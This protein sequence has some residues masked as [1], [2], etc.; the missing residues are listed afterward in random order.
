MKPICRRSFALLL[1]ISLLC[2]QGIAFAAGKEN[3]ED[4]VF[5][6]DCSG[7][8]KKE[9]A[10]Y[11][12]RELYK[13]YMDGCDRDR[14]HMGIVCFSNYLEYSSDKL[15]SLSTDEE[16]MAAAAET[17]HI[18]YSSNDTDIA[19]GLREAYRLLESGSAENKTIIFLGDG[20]TDLPNGPRSREES[21]AEQA[22]LLEKLSDMHARIFSVGMNGNG[23]ADTATIHMLAEKTD[24]ILYEIRRK[25]DVHAVA[26]AIL[27]GEEAVVPEGRFETLYGSLLRKYGEFITNGELQ[28]IENVFSAQLSTDVEPENAEQDSAAE[29]PKETH[30][31]I[32]QKA[33]DTLS[34]IKDRLGSLRNAAQEASEGN[35]LALDEVSGV[36]PM[37]S[38][39]TETNTA[40]AE[41]LPETVQ[42]AQSDPEVEGD[43]YLVLR[44]ES[45]LDKLHLFTADEASRTITQEAS[46]V[47]DLG[48]GYYAARLSEF[49]QGWSSRPVYLELK[50]EENAKVDLMLLNLREIKAVV[51][52]ETD[53]MAPT[54]TQ[55]VQVYLTTDGTYHEALS[56]SAFASMTLTSRESGVTEALEPAYADGRIVA[57]ISWP[58]EA[59][60]EI[61]AHVEVQDAELPL[62]LEGSAVC[63][64]CRQPIEALTDKPQRMLFLSGMKGTG[65]LGKTLRVDRLVSYDP[66]KS[67]SV[68]VDPMAAVHLENKCAVDGTIRLTAGKAYDH[69]RFDLVFSDGFGSVR[70]PCESYAVPLVMFIC[71]LALL[72]ALIALSALAVYRR[73]HTKFIGKLFLRFVLPPELSDLSISDSELIFPYTTSITLWE[74]ILLNTSVNLALHQILEQTE[75]ERAARSINIESRRGNEVWLRAKKA[76]EWLTI[77]DE[78]ANQAKTI[79]LKSDDSAALTFPAGDAY[80]KMTVYRNPNTVATERQVFVDR[81]IT[82]ELDEKTEKARLRMSAISEEV[83]QT[84]KEESSETFDVSRQESVNY[85]VFANVLGM[86]KQD[87]DGKAVRLYRDSVDFSPTTLIETGFIENNFYYRLYTVFCSKLDRARRESLDAQMRDLLNACVDDSGK[88]ERIERQ[89]RSMIMSYSTMLRTAQEDAAENTG[90]AEENEKV[91]EFY[92]G[93]V[94]VCK[95][96]LNKIEL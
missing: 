46:A 22:E 35:L 41:I 73:N 83:A 49:S 38:T 69:S 45:R 18:T 59:H 19:L 64:I 74:L 32:I 82:A 79:I 13:S 4:V 43:F 9:D 27:A 51:E 12:S 70:I 39:P 44:S 91:I 53:S 78:T 7:S 34:G 42:E 28:T 85:Y 17:G 11:S 72:L 66:N 47:Y 25:G 94:D 67:V 40:Q 30:K 63:G 96:L 1:A 87:R 2:A 65:G 14:T 60:L 50:G 10:S 55:T 20:V 15:R 33:L 90:N 6:I 68:I 36:D 71:A 48:D 21:L 58:E 77:N 86:L 52:L 80:V 56:A 95:Q 84:A 3:A 8:M 26:A 62:S 24:G 57:G 81:K 61:R 75:L 29:Q 5:V 23:S 93:V 76:P 88:T 16:Y 92:A 37:Q 89:A 31:N 54:E